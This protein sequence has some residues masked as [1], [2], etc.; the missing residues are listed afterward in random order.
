MVNSFLETARGHFSL[1]RNTEIEYNNV[2]N[3]FILHYLSDLEDET[4]IPFHLKD[5]CRDKDTLTNTLAVSH[6]IHLQVNIES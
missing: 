3:G 5:L 2:I 4:R 6:N 1:L